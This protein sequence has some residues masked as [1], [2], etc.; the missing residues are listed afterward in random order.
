M[1]VLAC[2][3]AKSSS[4]SFRDWGQQRLGK[5]E[6]SFFFKWKKLAAVRRTIATIMSSLPPSHVLSSLDYGKF[7]C[8]VAYDIA[9]LELPLCRCL[10]ICWWFSNPGPLR[11]RSQTDVEM[12]W[13]FCLLAWS[14]ILATLPKLNLYQVLCSCCRFTHTPEYNVLWFTSSVFQ[15]SRAS[16]HYSFLWFWGYTE[17]WSAC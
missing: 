8:G 11:I 15:Y 5:E 1:S 9:L 14:E 6:K 7:R 17:H 3:L 2:E 13:E 10:W 12:L 4:G 16:W